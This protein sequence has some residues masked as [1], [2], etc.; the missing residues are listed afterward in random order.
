[1]HCDFA[2]AAALVAVAAA[3]V[4]LD[5][6][7]GIWLWSGQGPHCH[8]GLCLLHWRFPCDFMGRLEIL[9]AR[10]CEEGVETPHWLSDVLSL[11]IL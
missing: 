3:V 5:C 2:A 10:G 4:E 11:L 8:C 7:L 9:P 1:M 6:L